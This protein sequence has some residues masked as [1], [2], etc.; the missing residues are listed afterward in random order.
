M[1]DRFGFK[2]WLFGRRESW[3]RSLGDCPSL[4][5]DER[6]LRTD[7]RDQKAIRTSRNR[8]PTRVHPIGKEKA[9]NRKTADVK[10]FCT[11]VPNSRSLIPYNRVPRNVA[12]L[13]S[14][15]PSILNLYDELY[16]CGDS[17]ERLDTGAEGDYL[18]MTVGGN[19]CV[20]SIPIGRNGRSW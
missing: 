18:K 2:N 4:Y 11:V 19:N 16:S 15:K 13:P 8:P 7:R 14:F 20:P 3:P 17:P 5:S 10:E 6:L 12:E 9:K 1:Q